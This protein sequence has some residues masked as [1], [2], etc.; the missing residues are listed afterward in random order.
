[1]PYCVL[2]DIQK[3]I[4]DVELIQ[5]TDDAATQTINT[6]NVDAAIAEADE[7]IDSYVGKVKA[8]P[9]VPVPGLIKNLSVNIAI[10]NLHVRRSV[11][12]GIRQKTYDDA[13]KTLKLVAEGTVTLGEEEGILPEETTEGGPESSTPESDR[14]F[15]DDS[16]S[17]F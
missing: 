9:L 7:L 3:K 4:S 12:D 15:T 14:K 11:V 1:M 5:L 10:W 16:L 17:G 13:L 6:D 2:A 8:V